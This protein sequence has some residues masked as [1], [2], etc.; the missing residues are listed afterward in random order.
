M[1][2][3]F[4]SRIWVKRSRMF[5][6]LVLVMFNAV[7]PML[8]EFNFFFWFQDSIS[9][10]FCYVCSYQDCFSSS[11]WVIHGARFCCSCV[12][13]RAGKTNCCIVLFPLLIFSAIGGLQIAIN[14]EMLRG[15]AAAASV[16]CGGCGGGV[17]VAAN[18]TGAGLPDAVRAAACPQMAAPSA[19][20]AAGAP[21]RRGRGPPPVR[22]RSPRR[23]LV[24]SRRV[25]RRRLPCHRR[26]PIVCSEYAP[27]SFLLVQLQGCAQVLLFSFFFKKKNY[28]P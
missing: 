10:P 20:P 7:I 16:D 21:R 27:F 2:F 5:R 15:L 11:R 19:D 23:R 1:V 4:C 12:Q 8:H 14:V 24:Q 3:F 26:Q 9:H 13:R 25:L 17:A 28:H 6:G 18:A 22:R